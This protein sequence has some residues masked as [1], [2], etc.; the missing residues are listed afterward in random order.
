VLHDQAPEMLPR[1]LREP[2]AEKNVVADV[3]DA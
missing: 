3:V 1:Q 2:G